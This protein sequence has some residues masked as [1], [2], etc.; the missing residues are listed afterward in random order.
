[1]DRVMRRALS[2][3]SVCQTSWGGASAALL[4]SLER[5][6]VDDD[7]AKTES[8]CWRPAYGLGLLGMRNSFLTIRRF[9]KLCA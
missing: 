2:F 8:A 3:V 5:E 4:E 9:A 6:A 7:R 1:M